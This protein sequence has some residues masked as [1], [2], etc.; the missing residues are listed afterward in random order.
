MNY[1]FWKNL[2]CIPCR[3]WFFALDV[4]HQ[5]SGYLP[6]KTCF[7]G[8][9]GCWTRYSVR[10][11]SLGVQDAQGSAAFTLRFPVIGTRCKPCFLGVF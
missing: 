7:G 5:L 3:I 10:D 4:G 1:F 9:F 6:D 8:N 11:R 2:P